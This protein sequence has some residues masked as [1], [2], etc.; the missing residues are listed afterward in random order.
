MVLLAPR[1]QVDCYNRAVE[2]VE[3]IQ[4]TLEPEYA[5][6]IDVEETCRGFLEVAKAA[7]RK[8]VETMFSD[9]GMAGLI[10]ALFVSQASERSLTSMDLSSGYS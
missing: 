10:A 8:V 5:D 1:L 7:A 2:F 4:A 6:R 9:A 3:G